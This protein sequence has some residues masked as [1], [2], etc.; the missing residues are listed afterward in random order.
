MSLN[1]PTLACGSNQDFR[2]TVEAFFGCAIALPPKLL[3]CFVLYFFRA[4]NAL[5]PT[6]GSSSN[7]STYPRYRHVGVQSLELHSMIFTS[8]MD[9]AT[10]PNSLAEIFSSQAEN[11]RFRELTKKHR[12]DGYSFSHI[13]IKVKRYLFQFYEKRLNRSKDRPR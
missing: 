5:F 3:C 4:S 9:F 2:S 12:T 10:A 13:S 8:T 11:C 1:H 7:K 6:A